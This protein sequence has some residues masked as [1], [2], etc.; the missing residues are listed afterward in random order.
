MPFSRITANDEIVIK[1]VLD[2]G[3]MGVIVPMVCSAADAER[4]VKSC[5]YPPEG[6][7]G[8]GSGRWRYWHGA[9]YYLHANDEVMVVVQI[10]HID[11]V[12]AVREILSPHGTP[13]VLQWCRANNV[14]LIWTPTN[15]SWMNPIKSFS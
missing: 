4:A 1:R 10:E 15:A 11:A 8:A 9:D 13:D 2:A 14:H 12:R 3:A 7:R 5:K 6:I